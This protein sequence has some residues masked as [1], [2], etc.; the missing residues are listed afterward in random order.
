MPPTL[1][2]QLTSIAKDFEKSKIL[3]D[4]QQV[5]IDR[6]QELIHSMQ[7]K[8]GILMTEVDVQKQ[9]SQTLPI[10]SLES[11]NQEKKGFQERTPS[12][13]SM[14]QSDVNGGQNQ[15]GTRFRSRSPLP[16]LSVNS[17]R[18][19]S[20]DEDDTSQRSKYF[21]KKRVVTM[22]KG[23]F[24]ISGSERRKKY[25]SPKIQQEKASMIGDLQLRKSQNERKSAL[26]AFKTSES[27][28][29]TDSALEVL[30][31]R[32]LEESNCSLSSVNLSVSVEPDIVRTGRELKDMT[33]TK[34]NLTKLKA[35]ED[36]PVA[37]LKCKTCQLSFLSAAPLAAHCSKH[38]R[39]NGENSKAKPTYQCQNDGCE[40]VGKQF[41][42]V[43]HMRVKHS[44]EQ[45]FRCDQLH[46]NKPFFSVEAKI[47]HEKNHSDPKQAQC[48]QCTRFYKL[49]N[50]GCSFCS[51][52]C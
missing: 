3:I 43:K 28:C 32:R 52:M 5:L 30:K 22:A 21:R 16:Y 9:A 47:R 6:Q 25:P 15:M 48:N 17:K 23:N 11:R 27:Y 45:L 38:G 34:E 50:K 14:K 29:Y 26:Q 1:E 49:E 8:L 33:M 36:D 20:Q 10:G 18:A 31:K 44:K 42:L 41:D 51:Q 39:I 40:F 2:E 12:R 7:R 35:E 19:S 46:C 37:K 24:N 4:R 13:M